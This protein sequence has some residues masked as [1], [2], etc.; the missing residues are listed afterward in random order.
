MTVEDINIVWGAGIIEGEGSFIISKDNRRPENNYRSCK[1]QVESTDLDAIQ[2]LKSIFGGN[3]FENNAPSKYKAF[4][5]AKPSWRWMLATKEVVF[6]TLIKIG[7]YLSERRRL[8]A[9]PLFE[10]LETR[11]CQ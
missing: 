4:P 1:I 5:N 6:N 3:Y 10:Y 8:Q 9:T 7:P 11:L 2:R